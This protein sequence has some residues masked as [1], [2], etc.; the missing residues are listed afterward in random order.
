MPVAIGSIAVSV[1]GTVASS[2]DAKKRREMDAKI[3]KLTLAEQS[4]LNEQLAKTKAANDRIKLV[5]DAIEKQKRTDLYKT[6]LIGG[7]AI[8][9]IVIILVTLNYIRKKK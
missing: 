4:K 1:G 2:I 7:G 5:E 6:L 3:A 8:A 9:G